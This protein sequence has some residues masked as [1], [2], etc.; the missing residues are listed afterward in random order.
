MR[1][2][3]N[4]NNNNTFASVV[5]VDDDNNNSNKWELEEEERVKKSAQRIL[6]ARKKDVTSVRIPHSCRRE[7]CD[8]TSEMDLINRGLLP[9]SFVPNQ[10][11]PV[12]FEGVSN[13]VFIYHPFVYICKFRQ[14]HICSDNNCLDYVGTYDGVCPI[15]GIYHGHTEGEK[16]WVMPE[17]RTAHFKK[18]GVKSMNKNNIAQTKFEYNNQQLERYSHIIDDV[19]TAAAT[20]TGKKRER[21]EDDHYIDNSNDNNTS[22]VQPRKSNP[23]GIIGILSGN[24][25][26]Q[27]QQETVVPS[28]TTT[29]TFV[30]S[31]S[32]VPSVSS[33]PP[34]PQRSTVYKK[35]HRV[36]RRDYQEEATNIIEKLLFSSIRRDLIA[37]KK[38]ALNKKRDQAVKNYL[39]EKQK[40]KE[41]AIYIEVCG[42]MAIFDVHPSHMKNIRRDPKLIAYWAQIIVHSWNIVRE[43]PWGQKNP[44]VRF[45]AHALSVMYMMRIGLVVNDV[46]FLPRFKE[47]LRLPLRTDLSFF[48]DTYNSGVVTSGIKNLKAAYSSAIESGWT[49]DRLRVPM[50]VVS[51]VK[52]MNKF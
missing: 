37:A 10:A 27:K 31:S 17:K 20:T 48:G 41:Y 29:T 9:R 30:A 49:E 23:F 46:E 2:I 40:N 16:A 19:T 38:A 50:F 42:I 11:P 14:L 21:Q 47:L 32:S 1:N 24:N 22:N 3:N 36:D 4:N 45:H 34:P 15:T 39:L 43:S 5:V 26:Q 33:P 6:E 52:N 12:G 51:S 35:R 44:G 18:G 8:P 7:Y 25:R 13:G 28:L